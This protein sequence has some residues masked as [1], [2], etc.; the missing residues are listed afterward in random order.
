MNFPTIQDEQAWL[1]DA[2]THYQAKAEEIM[3]KEQFKRADVER[4]QAYSA[5]SDAAKELAELLRE[6]TNRK[7]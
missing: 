3:Q 2:S 5:L 4:M 7:N 6:E 1:A